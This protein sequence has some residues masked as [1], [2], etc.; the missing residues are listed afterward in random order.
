MVPVIN[1]WWSADKPL[2]N[3]S[4]CSSTALNRISFVRACE[5]TFRTVVYV[6]LED[7]RVGCLPGR[8]KCRHPVLPSFAPPRCPPC[9]APRRPDPPVVCP[10]FG[11]TKLSTVRFVLPPVYIGF[12]FFVLAKSRSG[13]LSTIHWRAGGT[14]GFWAT[15]SVGVPLCP[16]P[17]RP[18]A[19]S[20]AAR[21]RPVY[22]RLFVFVNPCHARHVREFI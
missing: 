18:A 12:T 8:P 16:T 3:R 2:V 21:F 14:A 7:R 4:L 6:A 17:P 9:T 13:Q 5:K 22:R 10:G 1:R 15:R 20:C 19:P 11:F